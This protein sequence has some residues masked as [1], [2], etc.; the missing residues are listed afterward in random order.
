MGRSLVVVCVAATWW[1]TAANLGGGLNRAG[2]PFGMVKFLSGPQVKTVQRQL[3]PLVASSPELVRLVSWL[4]SDMLALQ[5][6]A[7]VSGAGGIAATA[8]LGERPIGL[9]AA[10]RGPCKWQALFLG[11]NVGQVFRLALE[12]R[13]ARLSDVE[14]RAH[15]LLFGKAGRGAR[16]RNGMTPV[17]FRRFARETGMVR[18]VAPPGTRLTREGNVD[19][20]LDLILSGRCVVRRNGCDLGDLRSG[21]F[22]GEVSFVAEEQEADEPDA[23][24]ADAR[25]PLS[26]PQKLAAKAS[27]YVAPPP[28][29]KSSATVVAAQPGVELIRWRNDKLHDYLD[30]NPEHAAIFER[31]FTRDLARKVAHSDG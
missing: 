7:A 2:M 17:V 27:T 9:A 25:Q 18:V 30:A 3:R 31:L 6:L 26:L 16:Y 22:V 12:R 20:N 13:P 10:L 5:T 19:R 1:S 4:S 14:A 29:A 15:E 28:G 24:T 11:I 23:A 21:S 8:A